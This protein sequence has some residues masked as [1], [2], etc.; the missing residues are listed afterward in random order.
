MNTLTRTNILLVSEAYMMGEVDV[1]NLK[2]IMDVGLPVT[3]LYLAHLLSFSSGW[4]TNP[5]SLA[6][7]PHSEDLWLASRALGTRFSV[8]PVRAHD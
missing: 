3:T 6:S 5:I 2:S 4:R 7:P 1:D 8:K